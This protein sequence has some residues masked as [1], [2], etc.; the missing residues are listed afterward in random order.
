MGSGPRARLGE[1]LLPQN[2]PGSSIMP[3]KINPIQAE[4]LMQACQ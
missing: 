1:L 2:E 4:A 3:G